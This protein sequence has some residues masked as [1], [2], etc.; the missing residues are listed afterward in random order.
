MATQKPPTLKALAQDLRVV[1]KQLK[2]AIGRIKELEAIE[3]ERTHPHFE[4]QHVERE[5][6]DADQQIQQEEDSA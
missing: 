2:L 3:Y 5:I 6:A 1:K 4:E